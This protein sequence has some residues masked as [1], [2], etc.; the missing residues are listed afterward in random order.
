MEFQETVPVDL[1]T[2]LCILAKDDDFNGLIEIID[3]EVHSPSIQNLTFYFFMCIF[4]YKT[5]IMTKIIKFLKKLFGFKESMKSKTEVIDLLKKVDEEKLLQEYYEM[6]SNDREKFIEEHHE[7][8]Q[9][10]DSTDKM[11]SNDED[12][13]PF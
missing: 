5:N 2:F 12:D 11:T 6:K 7:D 8:Q 4:N 3:D 1:S 9:D 10:E 13:L